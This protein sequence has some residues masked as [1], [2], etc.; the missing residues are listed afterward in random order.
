[1]KKKKK[2]K[3]KKRKQMAMDG[4]KSE[5]GELT[6]DGFEHKNNSIK[7]ESIEN[8]NSTTDHVQS[9]SIPMTPAAQKIVQE[10]QLKIKKHKTSTTASKLKKEDQTHDNSEAVESNDGSDNGFIIVKKEDISTTQPPTK[11]IEKKILSHIGVQ[12]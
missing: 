7:T 2:K 9:N 8:G 1:K 12:P 6:D 4:E 10:D 11:P 3:K 5:S